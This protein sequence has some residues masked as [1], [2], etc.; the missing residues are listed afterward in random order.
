MEAGFERL[1]HLL[2]EG[3]VGG[4][5]AERELQIKQLLDDPAKAKVE[6]MEV[7]VVGS[8]DD[9]DRIARIQ[10]LNEFIAARLGPRSFHVIPGCTP[11]LLTRLRELGVKVES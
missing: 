2:R 9:G 7:L 8:A 4:L 5:T 6:T 1:V 11:K 10:P 3:V